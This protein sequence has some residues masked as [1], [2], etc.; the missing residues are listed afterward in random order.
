VSSSP[1][2]LSNLEGIETGT[3]LPAAVVTVD[4]AGN[5]STLSDVVCV[6]RVETNGF[7][8]VCQNDPKC[9]ADF[10]NGC[11]LSSNSGGGAVGLSLLALALM[12]LN[13]RRRGRA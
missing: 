6:Q 11:S 5:E 4:P 1:I 3:S 9:A 12:T 2:T 8:D 10:E 13:R 7:W